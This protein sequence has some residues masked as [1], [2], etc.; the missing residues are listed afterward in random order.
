MTVP[1][2]IWKTLNYKNLAFYEL[3][4]RKELETDSQILP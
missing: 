4:Q 2:T 1:L 3:P